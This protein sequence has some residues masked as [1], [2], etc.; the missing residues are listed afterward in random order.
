MAEI[1][2]GA[3]TSAPPTKPVIAG[4]DS[5]AALAVGDKQPD[6]RKRSSLLDAFIPNRVVSA[7]TLRLIALVEIINA[8]TLWILS[9]FKVLPR[10]DEVFNALRNLWMT[11]GL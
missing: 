10:P 3:A 7:A 6:P 2:E 11:E 5:N 4:A 1:S 9:P 8:L